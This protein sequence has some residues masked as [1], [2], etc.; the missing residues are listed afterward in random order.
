STI[1]PGIPFILNFTLVTNATGARY[2]IRARTDR[3]F[4]V[5]FPSSLDTG[6]SGSAE[7][8][9]TLT[10][11]S[12]TVSGTDVTL[13]IEAEDPESGD[14]N[15]VAVRLTVMTKVVSIKAD[16][17]VECSR[18]SWELSANLTDGNGTGI[19]EVL[20]Y[21]MSVDGTNVTVA[22]YNASCCSQEGGKCG[23][24]FRLYKEP[25]YNY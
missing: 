20:S 10:A 16:C 22:S 23:H 6:T 14:S 7:G 5:S 17:P 21:V 9:V 13:T 11:P 8:T 24:M 25:F 1:E 19:A 18:A 12:D 3:S 15:Y 4:N 2:T